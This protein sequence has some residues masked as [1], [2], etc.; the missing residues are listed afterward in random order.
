M[1]G[2]VDLLSSRKTDKMPVDADSLAQTIGR[3]ESSIAQAYQYV[4]DVVVRLPM[5]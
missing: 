1:H 2:A 5:N 4:D 3:L